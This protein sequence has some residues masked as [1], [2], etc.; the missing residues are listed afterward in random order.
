MHDFLCD[1]PDEM[2]CK[3]M[4]EKAK[5]LKEHQKG[6][7]EMSDIDEEIREEGRQEVREEMREISEEIREEGREQGRAEGAAEEQARMV[8]NMIREGFS[9]GQII[10]VTNMSESAV[11]QYMQ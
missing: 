2:L 1:N 3:P 6:A 11:R 5:Y 7:K 9:M 10:A 8:V 4:A